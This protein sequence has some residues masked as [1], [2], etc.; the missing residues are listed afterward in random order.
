MDE[1]ELE[2]CQRRIANKEPITASEFKV[3]DEWDGNA[4]DGYVQPEDDY[5]TYY[6][7]DKLHFCEVSEEYY[8]DDSAFVRFHGHLGMQGMA[9]ADSLDN[10]AFFYCERSCEWWSNRRYSSIYIQ[11]IRETWCYDEYSD[12]VYCMPS[13]Q[14]RHRRTTKK[15][16]D[17]YINIHSNGLGIYIEQEGY[18]IYTVKIRD[19]DGDLLDK[20]ILFGYDLSEA[21]AVAKY[22]ADF[23]YAK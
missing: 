16:G 22:M 1:Q 12:D 4:P 5:G 21:K 18:Q 7:T 14:Q 9:H 20:R 15:N 8:Q 6:H 23:A 2:D 13:I 19:E 3:L 10:G 17:A 11:D